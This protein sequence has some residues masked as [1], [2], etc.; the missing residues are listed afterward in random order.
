MDFKIN[1]KEFCI[2]RKVVIISGIILIMATV[3]AFYFLNSQTAS[4]KDIVLSNL[5]KT[6][7]STSG[8]MNESSQKSSPNNTNQPRYNQSSDEISIYVRGCVKNPSIVKIYKGQMIIDAIEKAGGITDE[9]DIDNI[10]LVYILNENVMLKINPKGYIEKSTIE[11]Q[12]DKTTGTQK[13]NYAGNG[14]E[15]SKETE[16]VLLAEEKSAGAYSTK[17]QIAKVNINSATV[18]EL[19]TLPGIG[20]KKATDIFEFR[21]KNG[22]FKMIENI[23]DVSGIGEGAFAKIKEYIYI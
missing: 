12:K 17:A 8:A 1:N 7:L 11:E 14:V 18:E 2:E 5:V 22:N 20:P 19:D 4:S 23:M 16:G 3:I 13:V 9:A 21:K 6:P 10:N 15:I